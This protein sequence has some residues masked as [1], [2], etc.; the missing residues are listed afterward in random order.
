MRL[1]KPKH[2]LAL[3]ALLLLA[4]GTDADAQAVETVGS[5][6]LGMGGAW[7]AVANDSSATWWN[8][9][10]LAAGPLL[11]VAIA[12]ST[13][14]STADLPA[15]RDTATWFA[16][17]TPPFGFSYYRLKTTEVQL[18]SPTV[19]ESGSRENR[20]AGVLVRSLS[21]S[22]LCVTLVQT[23]V[24]G[25][26]AGATLKYVRGTL[27][28]GL[29][30]DLVPAD[31]LLN[32][33]TELGGGQDDATFDVDLGFLGVAGPFR[34]GLLVRNAFEPELES[35]AR[36]FRFERVVRVGGAYDAA[37]T[38]GP[39]LTISLDVDVSAIPT[40][41][42]DRRNIALGAERWLWGQRLAVRGGVRVNTEGA[43][44]R[45]ASAGGSVAI[46][47]GLFVDA[48]V[49]A[50]GADDDRGWGLSARVSF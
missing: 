20:R 41:S 32:R 6:A 24:P 22:Q 17:G 12:R 43:N 50:G 48:H 30:D 35:D 7:V 3:C 28:S 9:A 21:A 10:G 38:G 37:A 14:E 46:R 18:L 1:P 42:G 34:V 19:T 47:A 5:R 26:H 27:R 11:D 29:D 39:P 13:I 16:L 31:E 45:A 36:V 8:P 2:C 23:L 25:F 15:W 44:E 4:N 49:V 40:V 33:G